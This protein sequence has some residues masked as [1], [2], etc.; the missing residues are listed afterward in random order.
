[1]AGERLAVAAVEAGARELEVLMPGAA[2]ALTEVF[3]QGAERV[4][5]GGGAASLT[6]LSGKDTLARFAGNGGESGLS[7]LSRTSNG[8]PELGIV[9]SDGAA[10]RTTEKT[11]NLSTLDGKTVT[12]GMDSVTMKLG[13]GNSLT[14]RIENDV[15]KVEANGKAVRNGD[16]LPAPF[17]TGVSIDAGRAELNVG[18][19]FTLKLDRFIG[20]SVT[21]QGV[22]AE[23]LLDPAVKASVIPARHGFGGVSISDF[24]PR[25]FPSPPAFMWSPA[26]ELSIRTS[27][28]NAMTKFQPV[29]SLATSLKSLS[30]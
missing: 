12:A 19:H 30:H 10:M 20:S 6:Q 11:I 22:N 15:L 21:K 23:G 24:S 28:E 17:H 4:G 8:L 18:S 25:T 29:G 5:L 9:F 26:G 14:M 7:M 2:K 1:M 27:A 13:Q 16:Y 3:G